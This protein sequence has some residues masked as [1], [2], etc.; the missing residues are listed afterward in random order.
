VGNGIRSK[1]GGNGGE[2]EEAGGSQFEQTIKNMDDVLWK[3]SD[4][5]SE[6]FVCSWKWP[7]LATDFQKSGECR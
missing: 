1:K 4:C 6:L 2:E 5:Y 3:E 7:S